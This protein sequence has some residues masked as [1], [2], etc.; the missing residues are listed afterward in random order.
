MKL[1]D[2]D[3]SN[4]VF[5]REYEDAQGIIHKE[6]RDDQGNIHFYQ[7][8]YE[9]VSEVDRDDRNISK[10][11]LAGVIVTCVAGLTAGTIYFM[12]RSE[13]PVP[14]SVIT[15]PSYPKNATPT[16]VAGPVVIEKNTVTMVPV[17]SS[18][19]PDSTV[20]ITNN[21]LPA[22][23][24]QPAKKA[25]V[26]APKPSTPAP[27]NTNL[28]SS[29]PVRTDGDLKTEVLQQLQT[30]LPSSQLNA[31]VRSGIV[32][33]SGQVQTKDQLDT[34]ESLAMKVKGVKGVVIN[35]VANN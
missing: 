25:I 6:Y 27:N 1:N 28:T 11:L 29:N 5:Q 19:E 8:G 33:V 21:T 23:S 4:W 32:T 16:P 26:A 9:V 2:P 20:N 34:I 3:K 30:S 35:V 22:T 13:Q 24:T 15:V 18:T 10:G 14:V 31:E 12:T 7:D 17:P